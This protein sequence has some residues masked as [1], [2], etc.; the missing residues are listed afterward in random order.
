LR[1]NWVIARDLA[2]APGVYA[3]NLYFQRDARQLLASSRQFF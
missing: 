3:W 1:L 2:Q